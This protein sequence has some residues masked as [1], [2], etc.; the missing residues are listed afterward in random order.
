[1]GASFRLPLS[2][3][4]GC[5]RD[6]RDPSKTPRHP[7]CHAL[8]ADRSRSQSGASAAI[9]VRPLTIAHNGVR[10]SIPFFLLEEEIDLLAA[11]VRNLAESRR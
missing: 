3:C 11:A 7:R 6:A 4:T 5:G 10:A 1:M 9:I 8:H 2:N